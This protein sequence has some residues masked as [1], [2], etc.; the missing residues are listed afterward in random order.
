ML[1]VLPLLAPPS[2]R[3]TPLLP[4][5][6]HFNGAHPVGHTERRKTRSETKRV[7]KSRQ[8]LMPGWI[9][10]RLG[11]GFCGKK[12]S[13]QLRFGGRE[14]PFRAPPRPIPY[15]ELERLGNELGRKE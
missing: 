15:D 7:P 12:E 11:G 13:G 9:P 10:R 6:V 2:I 3:A 4:F 1:L 8:Q 14:K 5:S